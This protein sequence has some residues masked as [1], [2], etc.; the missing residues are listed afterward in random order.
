ML[1]GQAESQI[2]HEIRWEGGRG[3]GASSTQRV[4]PETFC[5]FRGFT[6]RVKIDSRWSALVLVLSWHLAQFEG[7]HL[8]GA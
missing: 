7:G 4:F 5:P 8:L 3:K 6:A 2:L 1:L